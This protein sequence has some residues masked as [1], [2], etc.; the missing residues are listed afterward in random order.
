MAE[1]YNKLTPEQQLQ[2]RESRMKAGTVNNS[3]SE[4]APARRALI[5]GG[6]RQ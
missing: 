2:V 6:Q 1:N 3:S 4:I 5:A